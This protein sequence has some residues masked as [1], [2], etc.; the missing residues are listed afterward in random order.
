M[1]YSRGSCHLQYWLDLRGM[2]QAE[3]A[4]RS[5]YS[6]RMVSHWSVG[7]KKMS[8]EAMYTAEVILELPSSSVLY[9]WNWK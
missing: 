6:P 7:Q 2:S 9:T 4:R 3:F 1:A 5:G 8:P